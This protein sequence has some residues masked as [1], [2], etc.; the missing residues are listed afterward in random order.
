MS[1]RRI[2][3][4]STEVRIFIFC[5]YVELYNN[6]IVVLRGFGQYCQDLMR[7]G[8]YGL[9]TTYDSNGIFTSSVSGSLLLAHM[10]VRNGFRIVTDENT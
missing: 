2:G 5:D 10:K 8:A 7:Q 1:N 4:S 9:V 6:A 3:L